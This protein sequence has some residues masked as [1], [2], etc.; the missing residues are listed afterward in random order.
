MT[1][2]PPPGAAV[3]RRALGNTGISVPL[4]GLGLVR[5]GR[6][7]GL[8]TSVPTALPDDASV[9]NLL[10]CA[11]DHGVTLLDTAPA[12]GSSEQRLGKLLKHRSQWILCSKVGETFHAG[13]SSFDFSAA[14][15]RLSVERSLRR[16]RTDY[17]DLVLVHSSGAD[18]DILNEHAPLATLA[19]LQRAGH[20]RSLGFSGKTVAGA[21][22]ALRQGANAL[23]ITLNPDQ[24][25]ERPLLAAARAA[26]AGVLIK[27][28]LASGRYGPST[29]AATAA[30][31]GV[32]CVVLGTLQPAHLTAAA[33]AITG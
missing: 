16:L 26:G 8:K 24:Q 5:I 9:S 23:M 31:P 14:A 4:L 6:L 7:E 33:E 11:R 29:L 15:V 21:E 3:P 19:D 17:L 32:S 18:A 25:D 2:A 22:L 28:P 1:E 12:Y 27:K 20:I 13:R 10:A 30:L